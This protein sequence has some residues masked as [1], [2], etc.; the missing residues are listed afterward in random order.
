MHDALD[1]PWVDVPSEPPYVLP[2]DAETIRGYNSK[3]V[4]PDYQIR[5]DV[6][7]E[8]FIG[9]PEAPVV[10]LVLNPGLDE[11]NVQEHAR[12]EFQALLR[13]NYA[14]GA[15]AF[16]FY[17]FNPELEGGG[18]E[19]WARKLRHVL[20]LF[21]VRQVARAILCVDYFPYHSRRFRHARLELASQQFG[22]G[23]V[24]SAIARGAVIVIMRSKKLWMKSI[25]D[26]RNHPFV[27]TL[28]SPQNVA[29]TPGN[30]EGF[31]AV[32]SAIRDAGEALR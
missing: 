7:P 3:N 6:L 13:T 26:L 16:P 25:P 20:G 1:N 23:L 15:S 18:R 17:Y 24:R 30:C 32:R 9:A 14:H 22:F 11:K 12:P 10:F 29:V 21:D 5:L 31:D 2:C 19:W 27:F 4:N 8:P 28:K